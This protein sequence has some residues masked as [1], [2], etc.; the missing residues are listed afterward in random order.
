MIELNKKSLI[1]LDKFKKELDE[2]TLGE[3][4]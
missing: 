4:N 2:I 3:I 1:C